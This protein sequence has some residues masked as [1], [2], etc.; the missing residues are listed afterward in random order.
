MDHNFLIKNTRS[1][2]EYSSEMNSELESNRSRGGEGMLEYTKLNAKRMKRLDKTIS[3]STENLDRLNELSQEYLF[4]VISEP[5]CGDAA[6][7]LPIISKLS[8]ASKNK[9]DLRIL[10]R[11]DY[12]EIMDKYLTNG[13]RAIPKLIIFEKKSMKEMAIWGPRPKLA[14][15]IM[16]DWKK[17]SRGLSKNEISTEI[18]LWYTKDKGLTLQN[19]IMSMI[20]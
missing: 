6:Q 5:W 4:L 7:N 11:D 9:I 19:E 10:L 20:S 8:I 16:I 13:A 14:Q 12:L 3:I 15:Q 17:D 2:E 1:Y 18:Q